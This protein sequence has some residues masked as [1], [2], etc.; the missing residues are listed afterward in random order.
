MG[1]RRFLCAS[2]LSLLAVTPCSVARSDDTKSTQERS[3]D[4]TSSFLDLGFIGSIQI[5]ES[6]DECIYEIP[7]LTIRFL[8]IAGRLTKTI[9]LD[10]FRIVV[11][12]SDEARKT[13]GIKGYLLERRDPLLPPLT[14]FES[15]ERSLAIKFS[16][17]KRL[18]RDAEYLGLAVVGRPILQDDGRFALLDSAA[19]ASVLEGGRRATWPIS[20]RAN[21]LSQTTSPDGEHGRRVYRTPHDPHDDCSSAKIR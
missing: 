6:G 14:L 4:L 21:I 7:S 15:E 16:L 2:L 10:Q 11:V 20:A 8:K 19:R 12:A 18:L 3:A 1:L 5:K 13:K 17:P 9:Y